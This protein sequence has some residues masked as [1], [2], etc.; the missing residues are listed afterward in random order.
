MTKKALVSRILKILAAILFFAAMGVICIVI[1]GYIDKYGLD[2]VIESLK[3]F[4][5]DLGGWGLT[6]MLLIQMLQVIFAFIP[7]EPVEIAAGAVFGTFGGLF[8][9]LFGITLGTLIIFLTV[10]KLGK[11]FV[12]KVIGSNKYA[13]LKF[14]RDPSKRDVLIFLL[15]FIPGTPKDV[16]TYFSPL[17]GVSLWRFLVISTV[18]RI[19]SVLSSTYVGG[20]L[21]E[22][23]YLHSALAFI[24]VGAVSI[25]GIVI[26][27][28]IIENKNKRKEEVSDGK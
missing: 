20:T 23:R 8:L 2:A 19:P 1:Y 3:N 26:Y 10:K 18:A 25:A 21:A 9:C 15:M 5:S 11:N 22:G 17:A 24:V 27:N 28:K 6:F 12:A 4:V 14:L 13:R 16:L 7:G